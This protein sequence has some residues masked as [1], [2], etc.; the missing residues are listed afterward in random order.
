MTK[1]SAVASMLTQQSSTFE[2]HKIQSDS[3]SYPISEKTIKDI[4]GAS[5]RPLVTTEYKV[6]NEFPLIRENRFLKVYLS[7]PDTPVET[8]GKDKKPVSS[9]EIFTYTMV[10][11]DEKTTSNLLSKL[12]EFAAVGG[13]V[14]QSIIKLMIESDMLL[15]NANTG[16]ATG[17]AY[18][19]ALDDE[20]YHNGEIRHLDT[21]DPF[22]KMEPG[23]YALVGSSEIANLPVDIAAKVWTKRESIYA[24]H[25]SLQ[26]TSN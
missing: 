7:S 3:K 14:P 8:I 21:K 24:R 23:D 19:L 26:W 9:E 17:A 10:I 11:N 6:I 13:I 1:V 2:I 15:E 25:N 18:D 5:K 22:I 4:I 16:N 20:Y 12:W